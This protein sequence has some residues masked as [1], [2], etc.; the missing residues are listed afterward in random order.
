MAILTPIAEKVLSVYN[1]DDFSSPYDD[2][3]FTAIMRDD[4]LYDELENINSFEDARKVVESAI[5]KYA[6]KAYAMP[7][8]FADSLELVIDEIDESLVS[9]ILWD[10]IAKI[11]P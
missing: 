5:S 10:C 8:F 3:L 1:A 2:I 4:Y 9:S 11:K 7:Y 6:E